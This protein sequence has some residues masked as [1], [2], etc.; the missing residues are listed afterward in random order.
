M[1]FIEMSIAL[2]FFFYRQLKRSGKFLSEYL[3]K[4][5]FVGMPLD[6][7]NFSSDSPCW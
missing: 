6:N 5:L 1:Q 4:I 3:L 7:D 2:D